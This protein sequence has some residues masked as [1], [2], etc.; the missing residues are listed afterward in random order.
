MTE[1]GRTA[2]VARM[3]VDRTR[4]GRQG[5]SISLVVFLAVMLAAA[6]AGLVLVGR[7][8]AEPYLLALLAPVSYTHLTLPTN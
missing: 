4:S 6:G 3:V 2:D 5:G 1:L 7:A 8:N